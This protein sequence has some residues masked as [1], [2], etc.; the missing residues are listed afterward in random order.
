VPDTIV[1]MIPT[2]HGYRA[3][4]SLVLGGIGTRLD[5]PYEGMDDLQLAVLSLLDS[6]S[7]DAVTVEVDADPDAFSVSLGPLQE[8]VRGDR[9][10]ANVIDRLVEGWEEQR[11]DGRAWVR[12][13]LR[14]SQVS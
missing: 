6:A 1:L 11:R 3:V 8:G 9:S 14:P 4:A 7:E 5:L 10:L 2:A 12:L 13:E